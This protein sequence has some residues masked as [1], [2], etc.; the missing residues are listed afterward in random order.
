MTE[1]N[2]KNH[3]RMHPFYHFFILPLCLVG[4]TAG[5]LH[6]FMAAGPDR[7]FHGLMALAF[8]LLFCVAG[9]ARIYAMKVQDRIIRQEENFRHYLLTGK[10]LDA[11]L[12]SGQ[13]IALRFASDAEFPT[14]ATRAVTETLS[15][16]QITE[17]IQHWRADHRRV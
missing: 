14:L 7:Y 13:I 4:L 16:K 2:F 5:V 3:K 17:S 15:P 11:Q 10:P 9:I 6:T 8:F 12:R 1:Q